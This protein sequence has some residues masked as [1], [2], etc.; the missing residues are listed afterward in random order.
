M[1]TDRQLDIGVSRVAF[2]TEKIFDIYLMIHTDAD[3]TCLLETSDHSGGVGAR[4][5][6]EAGDERG[7]GVTDTFDTCQ[8]ERRVNI[9]DT[10]IK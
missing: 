5:E 4:E 2:P 10:L 9:H 7:V 3:N 6:L 8:V 1:V